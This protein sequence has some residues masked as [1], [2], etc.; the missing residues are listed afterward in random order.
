MIPMAWKTDA[1]GDH[2]G[3]E[4]PFELLMQIC[5]C[6][7]AG[8]S[9]L[10][11]CVTGP[12]HT[13]GEE[14]LTISLYQHSTRVSSKVGVCLP[15]LVLLPC[16]DLQDML[17]SQRKRKY[18]PACT[19]SRNLSGSCQTGKS[20]YLGNKQTQ[21]SSIT[22]GPAERSCRR[23]D[24]ESKG[25]FQAFPFLAPVGNCIFHAWM[26]VFFQLGNWEITC[27]SSVQELQSRSQEVSKE[28]HFITWTAVF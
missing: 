26:H 1:S 11:S 12:V 25:R 2:L 8:L 14:Q 15:V 4:S 7:V 3:A 28:T 10:S 6:V 18:G 5:L 24:N 16:P 9:L 17:F 19:W 27:L 21:G 13:L 23:W 20:F 22:M